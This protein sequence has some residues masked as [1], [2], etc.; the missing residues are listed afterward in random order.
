MGMGFSF[1]WIAALLFL[2]WVECPTP[3]AQTL[4]SAQK[5]LPLA[6][7]LSLQEKDLRSFRTTGRLDWEQVHL[8]FELFAEKPDRTALRVLDAKD[9]TPIL[10]ASGR[11]FLFY[12]PLADEVVLGSGVPFFVL[13]REKEG[14][15]T[16]EE[17]RGK[18]N[19]KFGFGI[20]TD[21]SQAASGL[22]VDLK[23]FWTNVQGLPEVR[24]G[25]E[26]TLL[27]DGKTSRG[28]RIIAHIHPARDAGPYKRFELFMPESGKAPFC[29]LEEI[30]VNQLSK[31][32]QFEFPKRF[33]QNSGL[34]IRQMEPGEAGF[35]LDLGKLVRAIMAR[36]AVHGAE[37]IKPLVEKMYSRKPDWGALAIRDKRASAILISM[38]DAKE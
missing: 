18:G 38:T 8:K 1:F 14:D 37:E 10:W 5:L 28:G 33:L 29:T 13:R 34:R 9:G 22:A 3:H 19:L 6:P 25:E 32:G 11:E 2:S 35:P 12:D 36:M 7:N 30:T 15:S 17:D 21:V 20:S 16:R 4:P 24:A 27:L 31:P 23:S 26:G